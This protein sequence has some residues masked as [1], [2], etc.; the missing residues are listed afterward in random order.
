MFGQCTKSIWGRSYPKYGADR[1]HISYLPASSTHG[2]ALVFPFGCSQPIVAIFSPTHKE[3]L[4]DHRYMYMRSHA[5]KNLADIAVKT[6]LH[7]I[8]NLH[9]SMDI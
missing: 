8:V 5:V 7:A 9:T 6:S 3:L 4:V 2:T 1:V